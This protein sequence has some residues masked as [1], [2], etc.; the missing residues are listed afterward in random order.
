METSDYRHR[1]YHKTCYQMPA[2]SFPMVNTAAFPMEKDNRLVAHF[3]YPGIE[4]KTG[5]MGFAY[6]SEKSYTDFQDK[7]RD[8]RHR[9]DDRT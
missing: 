6:G 5:A 3:A 2:T 9:F 4:K 8:C 1:A 7:Y